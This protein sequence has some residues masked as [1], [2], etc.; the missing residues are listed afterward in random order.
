MMIVVKNLERVGWFRRVSTGLM[1]MLLV[2]GLGS[3][4]GCVMSQTDPDGDGVGTSQ[5][6]CPNDANADQ[7]DQDGDGV[8]DV[9][10]N[11]PALSNTDQA[12]ADG[13]GTGDACEDG[14]P[15]QGDSD[16]DGVLNANDNCPDV[17]NA[18]QAD[19]DSDMVGDVCDNCV[20]AA[21]T[22][23]ADTDGD[24]PGDACDNCMSAFNA[25]QSDLD[26]DGV[27]DVCDNC[28]FD[29]NAD[30]ADANGDGEGDACESDADGDGVLNVDDN[31]LNEPN[32]DQADADGDGV[33]DV[34]DNCVNDSNPVQGDDSD[35]DGLGDACDNCPNTANAAH[36]TA[37][38]CNNDG[39]TTDP[40]EAVGEQ[41]DSDGDGIGDLCDCNGTDD[42]DNDNVVGVC[43]NCPNDANADQ[44]DGD[45]DGVGDA[46]DNCPTSANANQADCDNDGMG[47][48]C[49]SDNSS[50]STTTTPDPVAINIANGDSNAFP[51]EVVNL[52]ASFTAGSGTI[53][54]AQLSPAS[55]TIIMDN[56]GGSATVTMVAGPKQAF[57]FQATGKDG[58]STDGKQVTVTRQASTKTSGAALSSALMGVTPETVTL[59]LADSDPNLPA[60]WTTATWTQTGSSPAG[61]TVT[62]T[63][64]TATDATFSA[65]GVLE[66]TTLMFEAVVAAGTADECTLTADVEI[67]YATVSLVLPTSVAVGGTVDLQNGQNAAPDP[68]GPIFSVAGIDPSALTV[69][70]SVS[71]NGSLPPGVVV[72]IDSATNMLTVD[73]TSAT[74]TI[75]VNVSVFGTGGELGTTSDMIDIVP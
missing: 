72:S 24:G 17:A 15:G 46:C 49:D 29:P 7:A 37:T 64:T 4:A 36:T 8:G 67:Q 23:Q 39:D 26:G 10:D 40:G 68:V 2:V 52:T 43:D 20:N 1:V 69:L 41:C 27:G 62:L 57:V 61:T 19:A 35:G 11:C 58:A 33:G 71:G 53:T 21:N 75:T 6:N 60:A 55:P 70:F 32:A 12:D 56:G 54:W 31:C 65:P 59:G 38:D 30:Q 13:N 66:T 47:D 25:V 42:P 48:P 63:P 73:P 45:N 34:C 51:C 74:G 16:G 18:D 3:Y 22:T 50:C 9:C 28:R 14:A 5:D 44:A